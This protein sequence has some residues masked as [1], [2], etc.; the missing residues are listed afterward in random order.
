MLNGQYQLT[1]TTQAEQAGRVFRLR[2]S[3]G[4]ALAVA[5]GLLALA[6]CSTDTPRRAPIV[7]MSEQ[8]AQPASTASSGTYVVK[9]G[10]NLLRIARSNNIDVE[11][12]KRWNNITDAN[13]ISVGQV[14]KLSGSSGSTVTSHALP[15]KT[16]SGPTP[17]PAP[18]D[19]TPPPPPGPA[20]PAPAP[21]PA[22]TPAPA[23]PP[24]RAAD[25]NLISWAWPAQ[26][27]V[28][29]QFSSSSKGIDIAGN[30]GD[31]VLAAADGKVK[32][33]GNG[34][35]GLGNLV[36]IEHSNGF[37]TAYAHNQTLLVNA[38]QDVKRGAKIAELGQSD[39]TSPR[40]HFEIRR[41]GTPVDPLQYLPPR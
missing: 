27:Q 40:L 15:P 9:P 38:G 22:P 12:L 3:R 41:Q 36:I 17:L 29:Q 11:S 7:E 30:P 25:A 39:T 13:Q 35:R 18:A 37:I 24:A 23:A 16:G 4:C 19:Q 2:I 33:R 20:A 6:G 14:I 31:P 5:S 32:Y 10:D 21:A 26:G 34:V 8:P 28:I 1:D